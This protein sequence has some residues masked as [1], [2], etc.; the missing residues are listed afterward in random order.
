VSRLLEEGIKELTSR[1]TP[2]GV[3]GKHGCVLLCVL[4]YKHLEILVPLAPMLYCRQ[5]LSFVWKFRQT[6]YDGRTK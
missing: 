1:W 5:P 2:M 6:L 3:L 4:V